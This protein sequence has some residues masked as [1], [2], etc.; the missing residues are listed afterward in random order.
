[1]DI[2]S[3]HHENWVQGACFCGAH[4]EHP[5]WGVH[6]RTRKV[7]LMTE[8]MKAPFVVVVLLPADIKNLFS[9]PRYGHLKS[10]EGPPPILHLIKEL[11]SSAQILNFFSFNLFNPSKIREGKSKR[12]HPSFA[13][14]NIV[15]FKFQIYNCVDLFTFWWDGVQWLK[16]CL[17]LTYCPRQIWNAFL[18]R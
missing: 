5:K 12:P 15:K 10:S 6:M 1:M 14:G 9:F 13:S 16:S 17:L 3:F 4:L 2:P 11:N 7:T 18:H 8:W